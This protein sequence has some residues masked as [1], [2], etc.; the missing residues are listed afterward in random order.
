MATRPKKIPV[1]T[2]TERDTVIYTK[3]TIPK[4]IDIKLFQRAVR[5]LLFIKY[6]FGLFPEVILR[7]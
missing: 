7:V 5:K 2:P 3:A 1:F 6:S 4:A